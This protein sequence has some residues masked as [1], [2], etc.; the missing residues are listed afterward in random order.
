MKIS[1][2]AV[3]KYHR[4]ANDFT[5]S[6]EDY[7]EWLAGLDKNIKKG[8]EEKG[9]IGC[10]GVLS[11]TRYVNEKNDIGLDEFVIRLMGRRDFTKYKSMMM[12]LK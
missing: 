6:E 2:Y 12:N 4:L 10:L 8:M 11:F 7:K 9:Y 1:S 5:P 3:Y